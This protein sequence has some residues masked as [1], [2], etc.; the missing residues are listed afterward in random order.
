MARNFYY[1]ADARVV[2]GSAN[3]AAMIVANPEAF[4]LEPECAA[5]YAALDATLQAA[6]AL[7]VTPETRTSVNVRAKD[8]ALRA[9][10]RQAACLAVVI[11][12][13]GVSD[14]QLLALGLQP[15]RRRTTPP[16]PQRPPVV[17]VEKVA[18]RVVTLLIEA[19]VE[20]G[21]GRMPKGCMGAQLFSYVN[22]QPA[23]EATDYAY[24]GIAMRRRATLTFPHTVRSGATVWVCARWISRRGK[25][26]LACQPVRV[27]IQGGLVTPAAAAARGA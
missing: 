15:R 25:P 18:G 23:T 9:V 12:A 3:F 24:E 6:Y 13:S 7:A 17:R 1:G 26:G 5:Q 10:Q 8:Q 21:P 27:T 19:A 22:D 14:A 4:H 2:R 20:D 11:A 16:A